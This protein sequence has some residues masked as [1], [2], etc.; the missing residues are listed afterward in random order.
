M[1][2]PKGGAGKTTDSIILAS[3]LAFAGK[4]VDMLDADPRES[5]MKW[6][7]DGPDHD[8]ISV[9]PAHDPKGPKISEVIKERRAGGA[10]FLIID[11][12]GADNPLVHHAI[13]RS[14]LVLVPLQG[15]FFDSYQAG[16][17]I[18]NIESVAELAGRKIPYAV[19]WSMLSAGIRTKSLAKI[20]DEVK[21]V[22]IP[23]LKATIAER[24]A[25]NVCCGTGHT[26]WTVPDD[27]VSARSLEKAQEEA[28]AFMGDAMRFFDQALK[29][30]KSETKAK[31]AEEAA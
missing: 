12:E 19:V 28:L 24:E 21:A 25:Y 4:R 3:A 10:D 16:D 2:S 9:Y 6:G 1:V 13:G 18:S 11:T 29:A 15:K 30:G 5:L 31:G 23:E 7:A 27:L 17:A 20:Q 22:G 26:L 8:L 14:H